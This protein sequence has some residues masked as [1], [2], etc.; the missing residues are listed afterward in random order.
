MCTSSPALVA[1]PRDTND[2]ESSS[3]RQSGAKRS[4]SPPPASGSDCDEELKRMRH[5]NRTNSKRFRDRKKSYMEGL[6]EQKCRLGKAN[7]ALRDDNEKLRRR[8]EEAILENQAHKRNAAL[9]LYA[10][11]TSS[12]LHPPPP[13]NNQSVHQA[14]IVPGARYVSPALANVDKLR[15]Q[16][17][18]IETELVSL[19]HGQPGATPSVWLVISHA[20]PASIE[21]SNREQHALKDLVLRDLGASMASKVTTNHPTVLVGPPSS[22]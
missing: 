5:K 4:A 15:Q 8:L 18:R 13:A 3:C 16:A 20:P 7:D 9:G 6:I 12:T 14:Q 19:Q 11:K 10:V 21:A 2:Q 1:S 17:P 22:L